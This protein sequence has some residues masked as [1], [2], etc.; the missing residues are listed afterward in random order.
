[1]TPEPRDCVITVRMT[2]SERAS[3]RRATKAL[4]LSTSD[5]VR[6]LHSQAESPKEPQKPSRKV[7]P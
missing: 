3:M 1:M 6:L 5:Y 7:K 2:R 4:K